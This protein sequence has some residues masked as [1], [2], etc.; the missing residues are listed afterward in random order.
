MGRRPDSQAYPVC[1]LQINILPLIIVTSD[2]HPKSYVSEILFCDVGIKFFGFTLERCLLPLTGNDCTIKIESLDKI[3]SAPFT[4]TPSSETLLHRSS[5]RTYNHTQRIISK[6]DTDRNTAHIFFSF[7]GRGVGAFC[8]ISQ[9]YVKIFHRNRGDQLVES[10]WMP[11][12]KKSN[13]FLR[14][15]FSHSER[16]HYYKNTLD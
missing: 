1:V 10:V 12:H 4:Q 16:I 14:R 8:N 2:S 6:Q 15:N 13:R 3:S 9:P 5:H 7:F 11:F